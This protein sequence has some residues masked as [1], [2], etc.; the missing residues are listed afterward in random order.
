[1]VVAF[2]WYGNILF[3]LVLFHVIKQGLGRAVFSDCGLFYIW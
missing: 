3:L 1:M 2:S